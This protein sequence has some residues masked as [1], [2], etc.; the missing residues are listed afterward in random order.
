MQNGGLR[1]SGA[2]KGLGPFSVA[3]LAVLCIPACT[4]AAGHKPLAL[5]AWSV[6]PF[7]LLLLCIAVMPLAAEHFWHNDLNKGAVVAVLAVPVVLYLGFLQMTTGEHTLSPLVHEIG[8]YSSFIIMLG[9]L[10]TVAGGIVVRGDLRP[11]P[12]NNAAILGIGA[13]L[14]NLIGTT[15]ASVLLIRP[16][17]RI[18]AAR[19]SAVHLPIFFIFLVSNLG[20]CL[21]P[22]GDPPL[23]MGYLHG[24]P[25]AW[26]LSLWREFLLVNGLALAI[27]VVWDSLALGREAIPPAAPNEKRQPIRVEGK[28]NLLFLA[29]IMAG[30]LLT[31]DWMPEKLGELWQLAG[32]EIL[33]LAMAFL[34]L[35]LTNPHLR[36][37]NGFTW[38]PITEVAILFAGIFI[39]MVPALDLLEVHGR[40]LGLTEP[41]QYFWVTGVLSSAL[42]NAPTYLA[43]ATISAGSNDFAL[44]VGNQVSGLNGPSVLRAISCGAVFM[45]A[46]TYIGN[47]PNFMV[48]A[49][50]EKAGHRLPSFFGYS[51]YAVAILVPINLLVTMIF[52]R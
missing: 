24:V 46:L 12:F 23:F 27:F 6:I 18:N 30:V 16:F 44:L 38:A 3:L 4:W 49:I 14:A 20:G 13:V 47:G 32:S 43:F 34:S 39:T 28:I 48:K 41:W 31:S 11:T 45:G 7:V 35:R 21:T 33:M 17:L 10:Y 9:S 5:P 42:D 36:K 37:E 2:A 50:G 25:F 22:L 1:H 29:G 19:T 52:F 51:L 8:K 26:T 15:G 40:E